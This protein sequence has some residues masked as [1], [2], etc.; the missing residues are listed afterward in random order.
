MQSN[1]RQSHHATH[2]AP[3]LLVAPAGTVPWVTLDE[4]AAAFQS[5]GR[6]VVIDNP[7][8]DDSPIG[9]P[10]AYFAP[11]D[12][13]GSSVFHVVV[14]R[15][16]AY[17]R[18]RSTTRAFLM[19]EEI[20]HVLVWD[21]VLAVL[22]RAL[23]PRGVVVS[24]VLPE[25]RPVGRTARGLRAMSILA[26][27]RIVVR[28]P[29]VTRLARRRAVVAPPPAPPR[30]TDGCRIAGVQSEWVLL[31]G[32]SMPVTAVEKQIYSRAAVTP[33]GALVLDGR[34][35]RLPPADVVD[36]LRAA[37]GT[38]NVVVAT[39]DSWLTTVGHTVALD[40]G[41]DVTD[42]HRHW[43]LLTNGARVLV[44]S[45]TTFSAIDARLRR[46]DAEAGWHELA[47]AD[48][49]TASTLE[50]WCRHAIVADRGDAIAT[51]AEAVTHCPRCKSGERRRSHSAGEGVRV[52]RCAAC[53]LR[54]SGSH[55]AADVL[56]AD[57]Y[58]DDR[59]EFGPD[60]ASE[61]L[62]A[63][64]ERIADLRLDQ[65]RRWGVQSGS[66]LDIGAGL[67]HFVSR[68]RLRGFDAVG[69]EMSESAAARARAVYGVDV[70]VGDAASPPE[71]G[72]FD[73]VVIAHTL[74]HLRQPVTALRAARE[75]LVPGGTLLVEVPHVD[76]FARRLQRSEW[77]YWQP[78][79]HI[80]HFDL[81]S[82]AGALDD[83]GF[84]VRASASSSL[85]FAEMGGLN[86]ALVLG[87][88]G[89]RR[90]HSPSAT[91]M[92]VLSKFDAPL[93]TRVL[94]VV[95]SHIDRRGLGQNLLVLASPG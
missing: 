94:R 46:Q 66:L 50:D 44:P 35:T 10:R 49:G 57:G 71:L 61:H 58:H 4:L 76:S 34:G 11:V 29:E 63:A 17:W 1:D 86:L 12:G 14:D 51:R 32:A 26:L 41:P 79:D 47:V 60:Y 38:D 53:G 45:E 85:A 15:A 91:A 72:P 67:G 48:D 82:L 37:A 78:G 55:L 25:E 23:R 33:A 84:D 19:S 92:R 39:D 65:L 62:T 30:S 2:A 70:L 54:Y 87:L 3:V 7:A 69:L 80:N 68:A 88:V 22:F 13:S 24:W 18:W 27:D 42:D 31:G 90:L 36:C 20:R 8:A 16:R 40:A 74:E 28:V 64:S 83:A 52:F 89:A 5:V 75:L 21:R 81:R 6:R 43:A 93:P 59:G 9:R 56:Y 73:V 77:I 95:A